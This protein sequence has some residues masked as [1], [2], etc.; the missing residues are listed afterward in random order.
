MLI[1]KTVIMITLYFNLICN[2]T[3]NFIF[4]RYFK[5]TGSLRILKWLL[6]H[7]HS[8]TLKI[9]K[10]RNRP[11]MSREV[12][13]QVI[14]MGEGNWVDLMIEACLRPFMMRGV[15]R[16]FNW[17]INI[18]L[19]S[20][21]RRGE[22]RGR[23]REMGVC[24]WEPWISRGAR[25]PRCS[26]E[27]E[28]LESAKASRHCKRLSPRWAPWEWEIS[29]RQISSNHHQLSNRAT[30]SEHLIIRLLRGEKRALLTSRK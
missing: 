13:L 2:L 6:E 24:L 30:V 16:S 20:S 8:I 28:R 26:L 18:D 1:L 14:D 15:I 21:R 17:R 12:G 27:G 23:W 29:R 9:Y 3:S 7:G 10:M 11:G 25:V 4:W 5:C 22:R 19:A